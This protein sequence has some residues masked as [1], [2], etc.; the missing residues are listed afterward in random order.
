MNQNYIKIIFGIKIKKLREEH[1][2]SLK[3]LAEKSKI[4]LSYLN[5]IENGKKHPNPDKIAQLADAFGVSYDQLVTLKVNKELTP[6]ANFLSL[7]FVN[8][9]L[10]ETFGIEKTAL[11]NILLNDPLKVSAFLNAGIEIGR[12]YQMEAQHFYFL[13]L[14]AYQELNENYF[15]EIEDIAD[16]FRTKYFDSHAHN[17]SSTLYQHFLEK[18]FG[19]Q[20]IP[21]S[22]KS[23]PKLTALRSV[24]IPEKKTLL[25][26]S[27]L[28]ES[29]KLFLFAKEI[30]FEK[31]QLKKRPHTTSWLKVESFDHVINNFKASYFAQALHI[32]REFL[33][34]D[35]ENFFRQTKFK[36]SLILN[37]LDKYNASPE[38]LFTRI[39]NLLPKFFGINEVFFIRYSSKEAERNLKEISK[40]MHLVKSTSNLEYSQKEQQFRREITR[41][42]VRYLNEELESKE[43]VKTA[44]FIS[45]SP[46]GNEYLTISILMP[47]PELNNKNNSITIGF[48]LTESIK[49]KISFISDTKFQSTELQQYFDAKRKN[50]TGNIKSNEAA[51]VLDE[52]EKMKMDILQNTVKIS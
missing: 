26:N 5:E 48:V 10:L 24:F 6:I 28:T 34:K 21:T 40:E 11:L 19:Y 33:I 45:Q 2:F 39:T 37:L 47:M 49:K 36:S 18:E 25:Y 29:Q 52:Y 17:I 22:F 14:R 51:S 30:G 31:L 7:E 16:E 44:A 42:V 8:D 15:E 3:E 20:I 27:K 9:E 1:G 41:V 46:N 12:N 32:E 35:L 43:T 50:I 13:C 38:M 23:Y 4:S